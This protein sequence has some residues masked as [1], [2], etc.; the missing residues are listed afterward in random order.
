[1]I[2]ISLTDGEQFVNFFAFYLYKKKLQTRKLTKL[3]EFKDNIKNIVEKEIDEERNFFCFQFLMNL[4]YYI[5]SQLV[6]NNGA[7]ESS[8]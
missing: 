5:Q 2:A 7:T 3:F 1:M 6:K 4:F 8:L